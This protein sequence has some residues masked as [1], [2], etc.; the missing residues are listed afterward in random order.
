MRTKLSSLLILAI[1]ASGTVVPRNASTVVLTRLF[2]S[3]HWMPELNGSAWSTVGYWQEA[4]L[5]EA[6]SNYLLLGMEAGQSTACTCIP[7]GSN[8]PGALP[9][10]SCSPAVSDCSATSPANAGCYTQCSS[11]CDC[12]THTC[13]HADIPVSQHQVASA[14]LRS[15]KAYPASWLITHPPESTSYDDLLWWALA[16]LR[17]Y[18]LCQARPDLM[19][20][21]APSGN[22]TTLLAEARQIFDFVYDKSWNEDYCKGGFAW[23]LKAQNYKNCVTNQQGVL[24]ASKLAVLLPAGTVCACKANETYRAIALRTAAWL[25]QAPMRDISSGLFN[26]GLYCAAQTKPNNFTCTNDNGTVWSYCQGLPLGYAQYLH[27]LTNRTAYLE[28]ALKIV[29]AVQV[30]LT[31]ALDKSDT[32]GILY[33]KGCAVDSVCD[34]VSPPLPSACK[35]DN[36]QIIFKGIV[37]RYLHYFGEY[38]HQSHPADAASIQVRHVHS[39]RCSDPGEQSPSATIGPETCTFPSLCPET[40]TF[41]SLCPEPCTRP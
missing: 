30:Q 32:I 24:V 2:N 18:D 33:E 39:P 34:W 22:T 37:A 17:A 23:A 29:R 4:N 3:G 7:C 15:F 9:S 31:V 27:R 38:I 5:V 36:N 21:T 1:S 26:D 40:C 19:S 12:A 13:G 14:I 10:G 28:D 11:S 20:C 41:P 35:C 25:Q 6:M 8:T 16:Y